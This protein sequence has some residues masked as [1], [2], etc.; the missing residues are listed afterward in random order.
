MNAALINSPRRQRTTPLL[1]GVILG[2]A[3]GLLLL[4]TMAISNGPLIMLPYTI[5][6]LGTA[7]AVKRMPGLRY[8]QRFGT[9]MAAYV[10]ASVF[11]YGYILVDN[12]SASL[13]PW[14]GVL[15]VWGR[16]LGIGAAI[17]AVLAYLAN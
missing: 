14:T 11:V 13:Q 15:A 9:L 3:G 5:T 10:M 12:P 7:V 1:T 2:I 16:I 4:L 17:N 6:V 8:A